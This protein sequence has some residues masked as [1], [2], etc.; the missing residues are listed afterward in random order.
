MIEIFLLFSL[1]LTLNDV[2]LQTYV[3]YWVNFS[4]ALVLKIYFLQ[5]TMWNLICLFLSSVS[6]KP[7]FKY[8]MK[9]P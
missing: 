5:L 6:F 8:S 2:L 7:T 1:T 9:L 3:Y 4:L